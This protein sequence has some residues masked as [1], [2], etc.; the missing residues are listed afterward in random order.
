MA[1]FYI[2]DSVFT[3]KKCYMKHLSMHEISGINM[4]PA[5]CKDKE[6]QNK[7]FKTTKDLGAHL[8]KVN[9][10]S[11]APA[12][13]YASTSVSSASSP[14]NFFS[15]ELIDTADDEVISKK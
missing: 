8:F 2:C 13:T 12:S 3:N 14:E 4:L 10:S 7:L 15:V 5:K 1:E 6:C 11:N 9:F